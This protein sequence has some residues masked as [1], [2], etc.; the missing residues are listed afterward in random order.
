MGYFA[1]IDIR[2]SRRVLLVKNIILN[3]L[4]GK[5]SSQITWPSQNQPPDKEKDISF[6]NIMH[7]YIEF[8][9]FYG[10]YFEF[11]NKKLIV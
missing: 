3:C 6:V 11:K 5:K 8:L 10:I 9:G 1:V 4:G 2:Q 7:N